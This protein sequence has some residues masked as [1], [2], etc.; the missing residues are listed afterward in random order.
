MVWVNV[1]GVCFGLKRTNGLKK[2]I[3]KRQ[4]WEQ[5]GENG[6]A[7]VTEVKKRFGIS[8]IKIITEDGHYDSDRYVKQS[9]ETKRNISENRKVAGGSRKAL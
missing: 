6:Q 1:V 8:R 7:F 3:Q 4:A 5:L 9:S 2:A